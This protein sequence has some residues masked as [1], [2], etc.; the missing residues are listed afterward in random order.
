MLATNFDAI[1]ADEILRLVNNKTPESRVLE[2][3]LELPK[4]NDSDVKEF[5]ADVS[6]FA[7]AAGGDIVYGVSDETVAGRSTGRPDQAPGITLS[8]ETADEA[9][10]RLSQICQQGLD[11]AIPGLR[12]RDI[13]K[14]GGPTFILIRIPRSWIAPHMVTKDGLTR[15][16]LRIDK[17]KIPMD[18]E[19]MRQAFL[20][21]DSARSRIERFRDER[22]AR[23][24]SND[25]GVRLQPTWKWVVHVIPV[26][27]ISGSLSV[28]LSSFNPM[29]GNLPRLG[30]AMSRRPNVDGMMIASDVGHRFESLE[31]LQ[32]FR[33]GAIEHINTGGIEQQNQRSDVP[34]LGIEQAL[35]A[36]VDTYL[37]FYRSHQIPTHTISNYA[38]IDRCKGPPSSHERPRTHPTSR[39]RL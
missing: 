19:Q 37:D 27:S 20:F 33:N 29:A 14:A 11:P 24:I 21:S 39:T 1:T 5:L 12:I 6:A 36:N 30:G 8:G 10:R 31:F 9:V 32:I 16:F 18:R 28:D 2:Y 35:I 26:A 25:L 7:N 23:I 34:G 4:G 13:S 17:A 15:F 3:K 22:L 38:L